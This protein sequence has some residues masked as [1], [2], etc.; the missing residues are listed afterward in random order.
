VSTHHLKVSLA[1]SLPP[2]KGQLAGVPPLFGRDGVWRRLPRWLR[3]SPGPGSPRQHGL[4]RR[5]AR[6]SPNGREIRCRHRL[7]RGYPRQAC[8]HRH[9]ETCPNPTDAYKPL[10]P[11]STPHRIGTPGPRPT[12]KPS[13]TGPAARLLPIRSVE[14]CRAFGDGRW[15]SAR[16]D[17][18][19]LSARR[20]QANPHHYLP[21]PDRRTAANGVSS[22]TR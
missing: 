11:I 5:R 16:S 14:S 20:G 15:A 22:I 2:R 10:T 12:W 8:L 6:L 21:A 13:R 19:R 17:L 4:G 3:A 7:G 18:G 9:Q 1:F